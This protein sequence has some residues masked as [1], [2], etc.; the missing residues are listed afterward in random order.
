[1]INRVS[2]KFLLALSLFLNSVCLFTYAIINIKWILFAN[3]IFVGIFQAYIAIYLPVWCDQ[4]GMRNKKSIMISMIQ[5]GSMVGVVLG[6]FMTF[7]I[8]KRS[9]V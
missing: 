3:R 2:R 9:E 1:V 7:D 4:F 6:Y 8:K 5:V